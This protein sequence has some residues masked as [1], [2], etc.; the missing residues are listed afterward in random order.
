MKERDAK[1]ELSKLAN[2]K[3]H[4]LSH[5]TVTHSKESGGRTENSYTMYIEKGKMH[6][7]LTW[8]EALERVKEECQRDSE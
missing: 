8:E 1:R 5:E 7:G 6:S 4:S 3:F 2:G